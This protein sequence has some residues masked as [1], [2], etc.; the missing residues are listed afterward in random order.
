MRVYFT[1]S[2]GSGK[3]TLSRYVSEKY[4]LPMISECARMVLSEKELQVDTLR[5]D[6]NLVDQYQKDVFFRQ[7]NEESKYTSFVSDRSA[8]DPLAYAAQHSRILPELLSSKELDPYIASLKAPESILFFVRASKTTLKDDGVR[9]AIN[10][11]AAVAIDS[12]IKLLLEMWQI[13]Y[14][15]INIDS[16][17]ERIKLIDNILELYKR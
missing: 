5:H 14:F 13:K 4:S 7:L 15:Q 3:S 12:M 17:Q 11:N 10:W 9:E 1:G 6:I 2:H 8:I 16:M